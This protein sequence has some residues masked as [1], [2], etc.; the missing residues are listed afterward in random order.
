MR[1]MGLRIGRAEKASDGLEEVDISALAM[2]MDELRR[3]E[4]VNWEVRER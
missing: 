1:P 2:G 3:T 4:T